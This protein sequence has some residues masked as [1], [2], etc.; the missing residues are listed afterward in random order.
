MT[1]NKPYIVNGEHVSLEE[2]RKTKFDDLRI[3]VPKGQ[4]EKINLALTIVNESGNTKLSLNSFVYK[5][6]IEM[7]K[8]HGINIDDSVD[9]LAGQLKKTRISKSK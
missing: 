6:I 4:K 2:Y 1:N 3:R 9:D 5:S 8:N 7:F